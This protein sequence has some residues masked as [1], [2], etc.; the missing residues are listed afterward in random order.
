MGLFSSAQLARCPVCV[1]YGALYGAFRRGTL[2][3]SARIGD[4]VLSW[5]VDKERIELASARSELGSSRLKQS[6]R[7]GTPTWISGTHT[8]LWEDGPA[9]SPSARYSRAYRPA[10]SFP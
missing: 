10:Q 4:Y 5:R 7:Q 1:R 8:S 6:A 3:E 9:S 2:D